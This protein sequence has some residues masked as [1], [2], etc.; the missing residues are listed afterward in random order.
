M[1]DLDMLAFLD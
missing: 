1:N